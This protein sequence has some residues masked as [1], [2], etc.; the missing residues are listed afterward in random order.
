MRSAWGSKWISAG[1]ARRNTAKQAARAH[2]FTR[3]DIE[4]KYG[5]RFIGGNELKL[6]WR[7]TDAY[8]EIESAVRSA[9]QTI[10][11]QFYIF[12][13][14]ETG[15]ALAGMLKEKA[16]EGVNVYIMYDHLGSLFTPKSFWR[17]LVRAGI[18]VNASYPFMWLSPG[19]YFRRDH[20]KLII[21]DSKV[22]FTGG[23]NIANEYWGTALRKKRPW[24]DTGL[25]ITGPAASELEE[26]FFNAW[27]RLCR[28]SMT[29]ERSP[30]QPS[31]HLPVLPIFSSSARGRR[32][33]RRLLFYSIFHA[34]HEICLTTAYFIPSRRL[35]Q[36]L[37]NAVARRVKVRILLPGSSDIRAVFH[38]SRHYYSRLLRA[39]VEI[40]EYKGSM[41]HAKTYTFDREWS[42]VGSANLDP[43]SMR[44][45][46][47]G[48]VGVLDKGLGHEL[49]RVFE[50]DLLGAD[51]IDMAQ[52]SRRPMRQ[53]AL[54]WFFALF[55]RGL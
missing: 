46:D 2:G 21:V 29:R 35:V 5:S 36:A 45:N 51:T 53:K 41:L 34:D 23:L 1:R 33:M 52:W 42:I 30:V 24:R 15:T 32:R 40:Y 48:N 6:L 12:R 4:E 31:G 28:E 11:L 14:D 17:S 9:R 13:D 54:E 38:A 25:L 50:E 3:D 7:G 26:L 39:G 43:R 47:E 10:C 20:R 8:R 55:R 19:K 44:W 37:S 16:A 18:N 49:I 22:A 27:C